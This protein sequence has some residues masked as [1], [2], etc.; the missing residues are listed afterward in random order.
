M[1]RG[2]SSLQALS[3]LLHTAALVN[4]STTGARLQKC[5][6]MSQTIT[7][8]PLHHHNPSCAASSSSRLQLRSSPPAL[9]ASAGG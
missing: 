5:T 3:K 8:T 2:K 7:G 9:C 6:T 4:C 1:K